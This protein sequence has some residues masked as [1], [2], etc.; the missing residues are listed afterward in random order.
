MVTAS[1]VHSRDSDSVLTSGLLARSCV[2]HHEGLSLKLSG[3]CFFGG[4]GGGRRESS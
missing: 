3:S 2:G 4:E 1:G